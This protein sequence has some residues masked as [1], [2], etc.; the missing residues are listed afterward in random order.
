MLDPVM[1]MIFFDISSQLPPFRRLTTSYSSTINHPEFDSTFFAMV[2]TIV[3]SLLLALG[4]TAI[5]QDK[6]VT[7]SGSKIYA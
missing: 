4:V 1:E 6:R 5:P 2:L 7:V 3:A